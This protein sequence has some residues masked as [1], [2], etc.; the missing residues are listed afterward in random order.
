MCLEAYLNSLNVGHPVVIT[1]TSISLNRVVCRG[2]LL[3]D[4]LG[5]LHPM[6]NHRLG[7]IQ[8]KSFLHQKINNLSNIFL[9][10]TNKILI[11]CIKIKN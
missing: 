5:L 2:I 11:I 3:I 8:L 6:L 4:G 9:I 10:W 7:E 1:S